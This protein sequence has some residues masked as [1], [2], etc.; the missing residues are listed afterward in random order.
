[1]MEKPIFLPF[2]KI[3]PPTNH[4]NALRSGD[5]L[6]EDQFHFKVSTDRFCSILQGF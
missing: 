3:I 5:P 1:M 2:G 4:N 6:I